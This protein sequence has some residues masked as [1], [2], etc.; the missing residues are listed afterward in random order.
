MKGKRNKTGILSFKMLWL[1]TKY[2][3]LSKALISFIVLPVF[4]VIS[5]YLIYSTGRTNISSGDFVPFLLSFQGVALLLI[6]LFVIVVIMGVDINAFIIISALTEENRTNISLIEI[7]FIGIKSIKYFFS[8]SGLL[9]GGFIAIVFPLMGLG[10]SIT[11]FRNFEIPNFITSVIFNTPLYLGMYSFFLIVLTIISLMHIFSLHYIIIEGRSIGKALFASRK[12]MKRHW[13]SFIKDYIWTAIK[14]ALLYFAV[15]TL[16]FV[17]LFLCGEYIESV[18]Y[19]EFFEIFIILIMLEMITY[20]VFLTIPVLVSVV[21][22]LFYKYNRIDGIEVKSCFDKDVIFAYTKKRRIKKRRSVFSFVIFAILIN[23]AL[24]FLLSKN[25]N[26]VFIRPIDIQIIAHRGGGDLGAENTVQGVREAIKKNVDWVEIDVQRTKDNKYI[27]NH[28]VTFKRVAGVSKKSKDL[29]LE[30]IKKF[31][32]K[33]L[34]EMSKPVQE[35]ATLDEILNEAK[36]KIGVF[37]ELKGETA[38]TKMV[39]DVVKIIK[40]HSMIDETVL[41]SLDY[42]IIQYI[43]DEYPEMKSGYLYYFTSGKPKNL[44]GDYLIMEER[45]ATDKK[46]YEIHAAGKKAIVWTV[47]TPESINKFI[48]S[49]VDG[50]ITDHVEDVKKAIKESKERNRYEII[51]DFFNPLY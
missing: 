40:E 18:A 30:E 50:V 24:S 19:K 31:K 39:D 28:D 4:S 38:D 33:N 26:E 11:P 46:I 10:I 13:K 43:S 6:G 42:R 20:F 48:Y 23:T 21:T 34:F 15:F 9:L 41:L 44:K 51:V 8:P 17:L 5:N 32:V 45:E 1:F 14:L 7:V 2:Q 47:N 3:I 49:D 37:V 25:F 29:T 22:K 12:L 35:V 36:G 27:I 16:S